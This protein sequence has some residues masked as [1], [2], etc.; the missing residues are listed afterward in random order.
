[1]AI[2][3]ILLMN[4]GYLESKDNGVIFAANSQLALQ[5][6]SDI[7]DIC[8]DK[9]GNI[10]ATD[11]VNHLI[12]KVT[13]RNQVMSIAGKAGESGNN[14]NIPV[15][16]KNARFNTP[17]GID[18]DSS[19]NVY[20]ADTGNNQIRKITRDGRVSLLAGDPDGNHGFKDGTGA[21]LNG[22]QDISV[23]SGNIYV[24]DTK[25]HSVRV[26]RDGLQGAF[27]L[28]GS[29]VAGDDVLANAQFNSPTSLV[30]S[31]N[32]SIFI[33]DSKNHKIKLFNTRGNLVNFA[34]GTRGSGFGQGNTAQF[35][36]LQFIVSDGRDGVYIVDYDVGIGSRLLYVDSLGKNHLVHAFNE[37]P[38]AGLTSD[39]NG[40]IYV[41][42]TD[43]RESLYGIGNFIIGDPVF[44][45]IN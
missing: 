7:Y 16:G 8:V 23:S 41:C 33:N 24:A 10:Y 40:K 44:G 18:C 34:G 4:Q 32:G 30:V 27:T 2:N 43:F 17:K 26:V 45:I 3:K 20:V 25:N 15:S 38:V 1:M 29:G 39:F 36:D 35:Y 12:V 13:G 19:G 31:P 6:A 37:L 21:L 22:P 5:N 9:N 42:I 28:A 11:P 14:G